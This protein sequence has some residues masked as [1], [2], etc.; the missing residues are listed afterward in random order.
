[1]TMGNDGYIDHTGT[2]LHRFENIPEQSNKS[3]RQLFVIRQASIPQ[4]PI[5]LA[6]PQ[7]GPRQID[8]QLKR[9]NRRDHLVKPAEIERDQCSR[10]GQSGTEQMNKGQRLNQKRSQLQSHGSDHMADKHNQQ[11]FKE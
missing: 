8:Q 2:R 10:T 3:S 7:I 4:K 1:M 9:Q 11:Q 6:P 5:T